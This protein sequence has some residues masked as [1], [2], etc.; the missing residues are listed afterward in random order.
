MGT[1]KSVC[2]SWFA[3]ILRDKYEHTLLRVPISNLCFFRDFRE[4]WLSKSMTKFTTLVDFNVIRK[5]CSSQ[6][7]CWTLSLALIAC[8]RLSIA[9]QCF[10]V[11]ILMKTNKNSHISHVIIKVDGHWSMTNSAIWLSARTRTQ[12]ITTEKWKSLN[13][14]Q[15]REKVKKVSLTILL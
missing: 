1:L 4:I 3:P 14:L 7:I 6:L 10:S 9:Q 12:L 13:F 8:C 15:K 5:L 11:L 2:S